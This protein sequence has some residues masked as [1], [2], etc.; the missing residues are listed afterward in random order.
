MEIETLVKKMIFS[1]GSEAAEKIR[2]EAAKKNIWFDSTQKLYEAF[3]KEEISGFTVPAINIRTLTFDTARLL[4]R[5]MKEKEV[6]ACIFELARSET[7]YTDQSM[8]EYAI[9]ILAAAVA[10]NYKGPIFVQGDHFQIKVEKFF[11]EEKK[12]NE[13]EELK[14]LLRHSIES[15]VYNIDI[16]A[17]TL[18]KIEEPTLDKQQYYNYASTAEFTKLIRNLEPR[19]LTVSIGGE[20]GEIGGKNST[21]EE[22]QA[23]MGGYQK[24]LPAG[25]KGLIKI[26]VQTGAAHGGIIL[27]DGSRAVLKLDLDV[28]EK[29]SD[30]ARKHE[31]GGAV[32]HGA[33]TLPE[34]YFDMF[35]QKKCI[36]VHL[37]TA[38]QD[39]VYESLPKLFK[40]KMY[41]WCRENCSGERKPDQ[42][43][44]QFFMG[45]RKKALGPFKK[46]L[47]NLPQEIKSRILENLEAKFNL[48]FEKL[49]VC[50]TAEL[51]EK[52]YK[53]G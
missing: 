40:E 25:T 17:S 9:T 13:I 5:L 6:G 46:E 52:L 39:I 23:F 49:G 44:E 8:P 3:A 11:N 28:L 31:M 14:N 20:I 51:M 33:S 4:F 27:P 37:A 26:S 43:D 42:T 29:L 15:G 48:L 19:G 36:E 24:L 22:L 45:T 38:F 47:W 21:P 18:V 53:K 2:K 50:R 30:E 16:D 32:Q 41:H 34:K 10:E 12:T 7:K 35:P 1:E